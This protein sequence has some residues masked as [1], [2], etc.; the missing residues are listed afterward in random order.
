MVGVDTYVTFWCCGDLIT[1]AHVKDIAYY[2]TVSIYTLTSMFGVLFVGYVVDRVGRLSTLSV[3]VVPN[4]I[5]WACI[6]LAPDMPVLLAGR[7]LTS[8]AHGK[9]FFLKFRSVYYT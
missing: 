5:G 4:V 7:V 6:A 1:T 9:S 8:I 3:G 2:V